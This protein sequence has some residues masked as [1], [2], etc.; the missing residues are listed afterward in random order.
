MK[1]ITVLFTVLLMLVASSAFA[2]KSGAPAF[3]NGTLDGHY[4]ANGTYLA[5][6]GF[7]MNGSAHA[8]STTE[9]QNGLGSMGFFTYNKT[10]TQDVRYYM[11]M[12]A[13]GVGGTALNGS[14]VYTNGSEIVEGNFGN[15]TSSTPSMSYFDYDT[16]YGD[17]Y[18]LVGQELNNAT[19]NASTV[20][21]PAGAYQMMVG[22]ANSTTN[23]TLTAG[24]TPRKH[25]P[26]S[27]VTM[28]IIFAN[29]TFTGV[30]STSDVWDYYAFGQVKAV[31]YYIIGQ[32]KITADSGND[33]AQVKYFMSN[34]TKTD[35][36]GSW[37]TYNATGISTNSLALTNNKSAYRTLLENATINEDKN[38]ITGQVNTVANERCFVVMIKNGSNYSSND[39]KS[40]AFKTI[41]LGAKKNTLGNATAGIFHTV[42]DDSL[43]V[44]KGFARTLNG[45]EI[46]GGRSNHQYDTTI[47]GYV[48]ALASTSEFGLSQ[49]N[50]TLYRADGTTVQSSFY[51]KQAA[52]KT[53]GAGIIE[54]NATTGSYA[55]YGL[56][57]MIPDT[58]VTYA[59]A[60]APAGYQGNASISTL[61]T[62]FTENSSV[63]YSATALRA[64]WTGIPSNFTPLTEAKGYSA[65]FSSGYKGDLY[66]TAQ[67]AFEGL[68]G[69]ID[70]LRLYKI[71]PFTT[72]SSKL[73]YAG[74]ATTA[75]DGAWWISSQTA[76]GYLAKDSVLD[77]SET[78]YVNWVVKD[79]GSYDANSTLAGGIVDPVV[80]GSVPTSTSSSSSGCVFNPA[81]GFGL[82][83][84]LLMLAPMVAIVRSRFK[85]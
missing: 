66:Y 17:M 2:A 55:T 78:Y 77:A 32:V 5:F 74:S 63:A 42:L 41:F 43:L 68:A 80:L 73:N 50:M 60:G 59:V 23:A 62:N 84:L 18:G 48:G 28:P 61:R 33:N 1:K 14:F 13:S 37:I 24:D 10:T 64:R 75:T 44:T 53:F 9:D 16:T 69:K 70:N 82:E 3:L 29:G 6:T 40:R 20:Y 65:T 81:A 11:L 21:V 71:N 30:S 39:L 85:K 22:L 79:N 36:S 7:S 72:S 19:W 45:A 54:Y 31:P 4:K 26:G 25:Y 35:N 15:G 51:G 56:A 46:E 27:A 47:N 49:S 12:N 34:G 76:G 67:Y 58:A 52:D 38:I 8:V 57:F 83:W